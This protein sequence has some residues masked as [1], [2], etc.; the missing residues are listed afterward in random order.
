MCLGRWKPLNG[1]ANAEDGRD[2]E[3]KAS[4]SRAKAR[5][6]RIGGQEHLNLLLPCAMRCEAGV[7]TTELFDHVG[8]DLM[9]SAVFRGL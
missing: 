5:R 1:G 9:V 7:R 4:G 2:I 8:D 3:T 6:E